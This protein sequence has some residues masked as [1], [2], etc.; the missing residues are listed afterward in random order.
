M[1]YVSFLA[2]LKKYRSLQEILNN[3]KDRLHEFVRRISVEGDKKGVF[4]KSSVGI[5]WVNIIYEHKEGLR[6]FSFSDR[7]VTAFECLNIDVLSPTQQGREALR[8]LE[9]EVEFTGI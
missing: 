4:L 1:S 9:R 7:E 2:D 3:P 8:L 5:A 6:Y